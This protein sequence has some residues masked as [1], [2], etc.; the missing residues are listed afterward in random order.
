MKIKYCPDCKIQISDR[1]LHKK[2]CLFKK[3]RKRR[4]PHSEETKKRIGLS[5]KGKHW[6]LSKETKIKMSLAKRGRKVSDET[7]KRLSQSTKGR[8]L[9][10]EWKRKIGLSSKG[11]GLG[12]K[13]PPFS[14][15][16]KKNMSISMTGIHKPSIGGKNSRFWKGGVSTTNHLIRNS[17]ET[18]F[19]RK[20]CMV[21]DNFTD[22]KTGEHG[23]YLVV[24]HINN[25]ADFPE[26][27]FDPNNGI[28]FRKKTHDDFHKKYGYRNNTK[29]QLE[30]FLS[31]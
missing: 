3:P 29:E 9:S 1:K 17:L 27:R 21:R 7:K 6:K 25:F 2:I 31:K 8:K 24:H 12:K 14:K 30:E 16:W 22:Q 13:R 26:L 19:W 18:R 11:R 20:T 15:E 5:N 23:G 4:P 10:N 28:T